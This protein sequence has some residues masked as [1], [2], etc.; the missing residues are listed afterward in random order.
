M[1]DANNELVVT[2]VFDARRE[3]VF[4]AF[5]HAESLERW[6][7]PNGFTTTTHAFDFRVGAEWRHT[8]H[9]PDGTDYP[10]RITW[11]EIA[12]PERIVYAHDGGE[13]EVQ[14][15]TTVTFEAEGKRTRVT[16]RAVFPSQEA[17]D[18]AV[19]KYHADV[20]EEEHI[21]RLG[22]NVAAR[23]KAPD[24]RLERVFA[25]PRRLVFDAWTRAEHVARWLAP[26]PLTMPKCEVDLRPGGAF[27]FTMRMPDGTEFPSAARFRE[28]VPERR[29]VFTGRIHDDNLILTTVTFED[30]G[31]KTKVTV[32]QTYLFE[33]F[34]TRGALEGWTKTLEQLE[35]FAITSGRARR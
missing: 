34:A 32:E 27:N 13:G 30:E 24:L 7:G 1:R 29:L 22:E 11:E 16:M 18:A 3:L 28:V 4:E 10:N 6:W 15:R 19:E 33:S 21:G 31:E 20:G 8:M 26:R 25:A 5:S 23:P 14:F 35:E 2:R 9:G 12:W 17:R